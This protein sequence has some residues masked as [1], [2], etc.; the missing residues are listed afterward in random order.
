MIHKHARRCAIPVR[1]ALAGLTLALPAAPGMAQEITASVDLS[2][3]AGYS[4]N[5]F[6]TT[7]GV[8]SGFVEGAIRPNVAITDDRGQTNFGA[9]YSRREYFKRYNGNDSYGLSGK[10][11]RRLSE[12]VNVRAL[13]A[14]DS[15]IIGAADP[16]GDQVIGPGIPDNP[17]IGLIGSRQRRRTITGSVG[18]TMQ[19][20]AR[21]TWSVDLNAMR[22]R[23]GNDLPFSQ[24]YITYGGQLGYSRALSERTSIGAAVGYSEIDYDGSQFDARI[25]NPQLTFNTIFAGGWSLNAGLGASIST[26]KL[27]TGNRTK[28]ALAGNLQLCRERERGRFCFGGSRTNDATGFGGVRTITDLF[29]NYSYRLSERGTLRADARYSLN[30]RDRSALVSGKQEYLSLSGG[31][32][33]KL[34]E[35]LNVTADVGYRDVYSDSR[36]AEA[37]IWG[38]AGVTYRLGSRR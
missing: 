38:R 30:D 16:D 25:I 28:T 10:G 19:P 14:Y 21:D 11:E 17:D 12:R 4:S 33:H 32:S 5:P 34:N 8:G 23:Y 20:T 2:A 1:F 7:N 36:S 26:L 3:N 31:Y 22:T 24:N 37:D 6:L 35:R 9:Y 15:S 29:A 18:M 27:P 13:L